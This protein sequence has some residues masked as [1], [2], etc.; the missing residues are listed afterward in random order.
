MCCITAI[1]PYLNRSCSSAQAESWRHAESAPRNVC[2]IIRGRDDATRRKKSQRDST[3]NYRPPAVRVRR[4]VRTKAGAGGT[5][6]T[7]KGRWA[8]G[9]TERQPKTDQTR[10]FA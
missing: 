4:P 6:P 8:T 7:P 5:R 1:N 3:L 2:A 9:Y 10:E